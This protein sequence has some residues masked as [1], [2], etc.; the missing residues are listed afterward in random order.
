MRAAT[1]RAMLNDAP[2]AHRAWPRDR[3]VA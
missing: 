2:L 1:P 3:M